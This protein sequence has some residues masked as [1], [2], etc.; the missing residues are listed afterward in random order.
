MKRVL[1]TRGVRMPDPHQVTVADD[2][3]EE[4][5]S[6]DGVI[7]H[8][9][10][11]ISGPDTLICRG[12]EIGAEGPVV[13]D[14]VRVGPEVRL[15]SGFFRQCV[16]LGNSIAGSGS[17]VRGGTL[18]E[19]AASIAHTVGLK[20]TILF[21]FVT[22]GSLVNFCD[23]LMTGGTGKSDHGEV[24]SSYIH[25]NFTPNQDKATAS[26]IGDVPRGVMLDR[27]PVFL[28]GQGG[29][30]G[31]C[32]LTFG[33]VI[34]AG[35]VWRKDEDRQG[36]LL[37]GGALRPVSMPHTLGIYRNLPRILEHNLRYL[38][39]LY[40]LEQWIRYLRPLTTARDLPPAFRTGLVD[41]MGAMLRLGVRERI[42][43]LDGLASRMPDAIETA[44]AL[45]GG[46]GKSMI[47][48]KILFRDHW[49]DLREGLEELRTNEGDE[50]SRDAFLSAVTDAAAHAPPDHPS[51]IALLPP[52]VRETG[53]RWLEGI[54]TNFMERA[55]ELLPVSLS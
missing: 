9:G 54:V 40:A 49:P 16:W 36:R 24:G 20:Q 48:V 55:G 50:S 3:R 30:V 19:E 45:P 26:L 43:R 32:R 33:T 27:P 28:G 29:L 39:E 6:G 38:A 18:V 34:A 1:L 7:L 15:G 17:H 53:V 46:Q 37:A 41:G 2:I 25:F 52:D 44:R 12:A 23:I 42:R 13:L 31:P 5:I 51:L 47:A 21:P 22:L 11:R 4:R 10:A 35:T 8:P 14:N